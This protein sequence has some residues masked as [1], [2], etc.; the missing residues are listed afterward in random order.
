MGAL[1]KR[2]LSKARTARRRSHMALEPMHLVPCPQCHE[3]RRPHHV[4]PSCG[5][6][7]GRQVITIKPKSARRA[8][9]P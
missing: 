6:Y 4:C 8:Q 5:M 7:R 9:T 2:K 1:P 3:P